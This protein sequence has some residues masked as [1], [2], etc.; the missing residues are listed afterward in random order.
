MPYTV[1]ISYL[2]TKLDKQEVLIMSNA[3]ERF[4]KILEQMEKEEAQ[5]NDIVVPV[6]SLRVNE[7]FEFESEDVGKVGMTDHAFGQ[8]CSELY[9]YALPAEYFRNLHKENPEWF[10]EQ[11]NKHLEKGKSVERKLRILGGQGEQGN[12]SLVRGIVSPNY[13][14]FDNID[15]LRAFEAS[16]KDRAFDLVTSRINDRL[17]FMRF[18]FLDTERNFGRSFDGQDDKNYVGLDLVN[19]EVGL[20]SVISNPSVFR[21]ICTNGMVS[22]DAEY[23]FYKQRHIF[24][25][26]KQVSLDMRQS[27]VHGVELGEEMLHN[28][29]RARQIKID[30]PYELITRHGKKSRFSEKTLRTV[31]EKYDIEPEGNLFSV[32]NAFTRTATGIK[33]VQPR[34]EMEK[35][36]SKIMMEELKIR[37]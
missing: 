3:G 29:E 13:V 23:G 26:P 31:R 4:K 19:S 18:A 20:T 21:L 7:K 37:A 14:P 5:K 6:N 28:M 32:V 17:M 35:K 2:V 25:N 11:F 16:T 15:A 9:S 22:K 1:N 24:I 34:L 8:L 10:A 33:S 30:N 12:E 36:A 27:I